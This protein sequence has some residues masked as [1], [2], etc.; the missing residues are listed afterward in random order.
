M[1]L[2]APLTH[3]GPAAEARFTALPCRAQP[4]TLGLAAGRP[5]DLAVIEAFAKEGFDAGYMRL[6]DAPFTQLDYVI[7]A[8]AP[9]D[10]RAAWYSETRHLAPAMLIEAGLHLGRRNGAPFL[11]CHGLWRD[12]SGSGPEPATQMGH[13]L[14]PDSI[15]AEDVT[16]QGWGLSGA[17]FE[18]QPDA[19]TGFDLFTPVATGLAGGGTGA[20]LC[21]LGPNENPHALLPQVSHD[22]PRARIEGIG[23][24]IRT[25]FE[26]V[27]QDSYA[28]E[29]LLHHG[30]FDGQAVRIEASSVGFDGVAARG[31]LSPDGNRTCIT[32]ELLI[33]GE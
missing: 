19:E 20:L 9:G 8:R 7:P 24:L 27:C 1:S 26:Q 12:T 17:R 33:L 2:P 30:E 21:K 14:M 6:R 16:A 13:L 11:H 28:T 22:L 5:F 10:G 29:V 3:P 25:S 31:T 15:L 32:A 18:V 4:V 23:S